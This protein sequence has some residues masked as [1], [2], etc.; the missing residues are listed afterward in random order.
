MCQSRHKAG[1]VVFAQL[2]AF[3]LVTGHQEV[4][5][6]LVVHLQ[7]GEADLELALALLL[8]LHAHSEEVP[9]SQHHHTGAA[10]GF[11]RTHH[12]VRLSSARG[13]IGENRRI[14]TVHH[15][16]EHRFAGTLVDL[17]LA[18]VLI[19][20]HVEGQL[21]VAMSSRMVW[22]TLYGFILL[23]WIK[24]HNLTV[25]WFHNNTMILIFT[26]CT[27]LRSKSHTD[28]DVGTSLANAVALLLKHSFGRLRLQTSHRLGCGS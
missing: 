2:Q 21:H 28:H 27:A 14:E 13:T 11:A 8:A 9:Q 6:G 19:Q 18:G 24:Y 25:Q 10:F 26:F 5:N 16:L 23:G 1:A 7:V 17:T 3:G 15:W 20:Y 4:T 12:G 22:H